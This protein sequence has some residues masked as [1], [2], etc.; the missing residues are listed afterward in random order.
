M[1]VTLARQEPL[2]SRKTG[3]ISLCWGNWHCSSLV[4]WQFAQ[5]KYLKP[6]AIS[7]H[8]FVG[9]PLVVW[10]LSVDCLAAECQTTVDQRFFGRVVLHDYP[11]TMPCFFQ[12]LMTCYMYIRLPCSGQFF[13]FWKTIMLHFENDNQI[14]KWM[15][16][17]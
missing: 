5:I 1:F 10:Q 9:D 8:L 15:P 16:R 4:I 7:S 6:L 2:L 17:E 11:K 12:N 14:L 13:S 3:F